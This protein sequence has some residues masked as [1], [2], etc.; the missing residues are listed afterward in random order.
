MRTPPGG[1]PAP[2]PNC[3]CPAF[4]TIH[5]YAPGTIKGQRR[6]LEV[7][8]GDDWENGVLLVLSIVASANVPSFNKETEETGE[9]RGGAGGSHLNF[10][11]LVFFL[12][13][14]IG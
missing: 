14:P 6:P 5:T 7:K 13:F 1:I 11:G 2:A 10:M 9:G 4:F 3:F 12:F 8:L